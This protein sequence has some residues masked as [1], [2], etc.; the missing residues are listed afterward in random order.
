MAYRKLNID[1]HKRESLK[2]MKAIFQNIKTW[3]LTTSTK[4]VITEE[5]SN[6][7]VF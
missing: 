7:E 5:D 6:L 4:I 3:G 1:L 2:I